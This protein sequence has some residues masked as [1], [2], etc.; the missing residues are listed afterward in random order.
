M[1]IILFFLII[2][3]IYG[4]IIFFPIPKHHVEGLCINVTNNQSINCP[5]ERGICYLDT[6]WKCRC[7]TEY[8]NYDTSSPNLCGKKRLDRV[9]IALLSFIFGW[10]GYISYKM[11]W[12]G[13]YI[14]HEIIL[15]LFILSIVVFCKY[16]REGITQRGEIKINT[17]VNR[18]YTVTSILLIT[19]WLYTIILSIFYPYNGDGAINYI[20][21][22]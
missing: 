6:V 12:W 11:E 19:I 9:Y 16:Y 7:H 13:I 1:K 17:L 15:F 5:T 21:K 4:N 18:F 2:N 20:K 10:S 14:I 8:Y 22:N 3:S